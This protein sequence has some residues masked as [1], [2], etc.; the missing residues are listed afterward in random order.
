MILI[1]E[2]KHD[3]DIGNIVTAPK[4]LLIFSISAFLSTL[5]HNYTIVKQYTVSEIMQS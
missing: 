5:L 4:K 3:R 2:I 1:P